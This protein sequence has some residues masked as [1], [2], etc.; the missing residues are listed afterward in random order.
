MYLLLYL[1]HACAQ[2]NTHAARTHTHTHTHKELK[3]TCMKEGEHGTH[4][5][6]HAHTHT[7]THTLSNQMALGSWKAACGVI[8]IPEADPAAQARVPFPPTTWHGSGSARGGARPREKREDETHCG[9]PPCVRALS[10]LYPFVQKRG[11]ARC[12]KKQQQNLRPS[13]IG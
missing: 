11:G 12:C 9:N 3:I 1:Q 7:H 6:T 10:T 8:P 2:T 13:A 5:H 4:A